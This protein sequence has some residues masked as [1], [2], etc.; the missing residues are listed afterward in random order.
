MMQSANSPDRP[1]PQPFV[2]RTTASNLLAKFLPGAR[3]E[4][5]MDL[6]LSP[7]SKTPVKHTESTTFGTPPSQPS[8]SNALSNPSSTKSRNRITI[9]LL[10]DEDEEDEEDELQQPIPVAEKEDEVIEYATPTRGLR[11]R[12]QNKSVKALENAYVTPK[13]PRPKK[14]ARN[15][16]SDLIGADIGLDL[17]PIVSARVAI[18][19]EIATKTASYRDS[20][21]VEKKEF[22]LPLLPPHNYVKKLVEKHECMSAAELAALPTSTPYVEIETQPRGVQATMKPYQ[23]SGLSFMLYLHRNVSHRFTPENIIVWRN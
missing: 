20:F 16:I 3:T 7:R 1:L 2:R 21:L 5:K 12:R 6:H 15:A 23:L 17:T 8:F 9:D 18:R 13:R 10:D 19:Q 14:G 11:P 22:W 4:H